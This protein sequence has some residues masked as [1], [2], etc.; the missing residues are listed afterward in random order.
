MTYFDPE[1]NEKYLPYVVEPSLGADRV[2]LAFLCQAYDEETLE[3]GDNRVVLRF[4]PAL[5]PIKIGI[6]PLSNKLAHRADE[7]FRLLSPHYQCEVDTRQS[8]GKR[9]RRQD[10]VGTPYCVTYDFDSEDDQAVTIRER[11]SM[12]QVRVPI[13]ELVEWFKGRFE[14]DWTPKHF[15]EV[16]TEE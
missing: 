14:F 5:A 7:L 3:N 8:I 1:T 15:E 9:Y 6:L 11:D 12:T 10:E 2:T 16:K 4:H 13:D